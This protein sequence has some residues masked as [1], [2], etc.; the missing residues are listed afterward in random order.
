[1]EA[2]EYGEEPVLIFGNQMLAFSLSACLLQAG[3]PVTVYTSRMEAARD[4]I[5]GHRAALL[6]QGSAIWEKS[7]L[8]VT[9]KTDQDARFKLAFALTCEN[10]AEKK[11]TL[12]LLEHVLPVDAIIAINTESIP[13]SSLQE[14]TRYPARILG[15]NWVEPVHTTSFLELIT[16]DVCDGHIGNDLLQQGRSKWRKDPYLISHDLGIRSKMM[17]A[18]ARE[19]FYLVQHEYA[20]VED[21]DR[22]C[23]NDAGYYLPF[24]GNFRYMDLMG[25]YAYG[26]VMEELNPVLSNDPHMPA[27]FKNLLQAGSRGMENDDGFYTYEEKEVEKW[28]QLFQGFSYQI[29]KIIRKYPFQYKDGASGTGLDQTATT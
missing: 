23:R 4:A 9:D 29:E 11:T 27:F 15:A 12:A 17:A 1:M 28:H 18:M 7:A 8:V 25:T 6:K 16:N 14:G 26:M 10:L 5:R 19:A 3:H 2:I 20:S 24:A 22:A 21:I 13:L